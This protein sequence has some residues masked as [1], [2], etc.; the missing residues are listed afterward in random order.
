MRIEIFDVEHGQCTLL[1]SDTGAHMLIDAGHNASTG[2]RPSSMLRNRG[3][4]TVDKLVV[5]NYD[6]DHVSDLANVLQV[7][8]IR[9]LTRNR[10]VS[11]SALLELKELGGVGNGIRALS[12]MLDRYVYP[13]SDKPN[14]GSL[15]EFTSYN[16]Y[17]TDFEDENNL[18]VLHVMSWPQLKIAFTGDLETAAWKKLLQQSQVREALADVNVF[19]ASHHGRLN[20]Y[21]DEIFD[22]TGMSPAI[23]VISDSGIDYET[24]KSGPLYRARATGINLY[25]ETRKVL[26]TRRDGTITIDFDD[27][28]ATVST[29]KRGP[30]LF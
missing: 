16:T 12:G 28:R 1:T 22:T 17:P 6:E 10:T 11:G 24:Q 20:G 3:I 19:M 14:F 30:R 29:S 2:W 9:I 15:K 13:V 7:A 4:S 26:T 27:H 8:D 5:T 25:G 18:S 23:V 21:C